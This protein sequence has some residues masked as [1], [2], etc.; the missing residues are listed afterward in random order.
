MRWACPRPS[1]VL[2]VLTRH[3]KQ[4]LYAKPLNRSSEKRLDSFRWLVIDLVNRLPMKY[5]TID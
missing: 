3:E 1:T 5:N 2:V 4:Q